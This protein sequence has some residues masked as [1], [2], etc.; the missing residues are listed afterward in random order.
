MWNVAIALSLLVL[1][2][3]PARADLIVVD[4]NPFEDIHQIRRVRMTMTHGL[5][6]ETAPLWK[7]V[8]FEGAP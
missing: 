3:A 4:G 5:L 7:S 8:G 6:Y 1:A 2:Q